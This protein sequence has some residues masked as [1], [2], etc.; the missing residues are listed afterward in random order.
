MNIKIVLGGNETRTVL[1][2]ATFLVTGNNL[3]FMGD[4]STRALL[5][6]LDPQIERPEEREFSVDLRTYIPEH[7]TD[8][9][10]AGLIILRAYDVAGKPLQNIKPFG[11]FEEWSNWIRPP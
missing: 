10:N 1:T 8:L 11:R 2:N 9:V 3:V 5:C 6:K 7:P 4:I